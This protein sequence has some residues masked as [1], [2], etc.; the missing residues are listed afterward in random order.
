MNNCILVDW[1]LFH[2]NPYTQDFVVARDGQVKMVLLVSDPYG[3]DYDPESPYFSDGREFPLPDIDWDVIIRNTG[4]LPSVIFKAKALGVLHEASDLRAVIG[5][6]RDSQVNRIYREEG[7]L[8]TV[9]D[10]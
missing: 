9:E 5:L 7:V 10:F 8:V 6:D 4:R 1:A 3:D 2:T